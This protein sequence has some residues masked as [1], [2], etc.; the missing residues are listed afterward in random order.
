[1][2]K[3]KIVEE[4]E[5]GLSVDLQELA[6]EHIEEPKPKTKKVSGVFVI[7]K[8]FEYNGIEYLA[9]DKFI[10]H[11]GWVR[12]TEYD[13]FAKVQSVKQRKA[14]GIAF[15]YPGEIIDQKTKERAQHRA[16]LPLKEE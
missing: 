15:L 6:A 1:M 9:G 14:P 13:D 12:D 11:A 8:D 2:P 4:F 16:I 7:Y 5:A 10:P 3:K